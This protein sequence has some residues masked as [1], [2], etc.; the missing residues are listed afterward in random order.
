MKK[1]RRRGRII[2]LIRVTAIAPQ[3]RIGR[4]L[5]LAVGLALTINLKRFETRRNDLEPLA[6]KL[7]DDRLAEELLPLVPC[8]KKII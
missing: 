7:A 4:N 8:L 5:D 6:D 3:V 2:T 1:K